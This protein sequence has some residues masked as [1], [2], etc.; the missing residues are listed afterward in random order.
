M[1]N[2]PCVYLRLR[3]RRLHRRKVA[4]SRCIQVVRGRGV[5]RLK[6][7]G[8]ALERLRPSNFFSFYGKVYVLYT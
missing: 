1:E 2:P 4:R 6:I 3:R 8:S 7:V 5:W